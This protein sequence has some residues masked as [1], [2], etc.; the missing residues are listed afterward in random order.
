MIGANLF[1]GTGLD[2]LPSVILMA[3]QSVQQILQVSSAEN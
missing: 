1:A 2:G 3:L